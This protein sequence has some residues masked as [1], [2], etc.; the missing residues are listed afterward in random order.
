MKLTPKQEKFAQ[1]VASGKSQADAYRGAFEVTTKRAATVQEAAS[2]LMKKQE[3]KS[4]VHEIRSEIQRKVIE[5]TAITVDVKVKQALWE[6]FQ[7]KS[8][9]EKF[10]SDA[11]SVSLAK[12][13]DGMRALNQMRAVGRWTRYSVLKR[14][15]FKCQACGSKPTKDSDVVLHIDHIVPVTLGGTSDESNLQVLCRPC[16]LSKSNRYAFD[17]NKEHDHAH[18]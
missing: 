6:T 5:E 18:A 14:A 16:N 4:R 11:V 12:V 8:D 1:L 9:I 2:R 13:Q 15:G 17:H 7:N 10:C 3:V